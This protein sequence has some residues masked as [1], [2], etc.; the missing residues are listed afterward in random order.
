RAVA[1]QAKTNNQVVQKILT[2]YEEM[3]TEIQKVTHS[4]Y[5]IKIMDALFA[6]PIFHSNDFRKKAG[7]APKTA[8]SL[9]SLLKKAGIVQEQ[10][11]S[12]GRVPSL[13]AFERLVKLIGDN[14]FN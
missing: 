11:P 7:L 3:K 5:S 4:Q 2:L 8:S 14:D 1:E 6:S 13:L 12:R 9:L 10:E